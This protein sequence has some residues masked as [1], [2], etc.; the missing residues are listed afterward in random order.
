MREWADEGERGRPCQST[1]RAPIIMWAVLLAVPFLQRCHVSKYLS[2]AE[3]Q[4]EVSA[5]DTADERWPI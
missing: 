1:E 4:A 2:V 3:L 5:E